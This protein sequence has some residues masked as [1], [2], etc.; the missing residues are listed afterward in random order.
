LKHWLAALRGG[1]L[2]RVS[3]NALEGLADFV[4]EA[5][6]DLAGLGDFVE[7]DDTDAAFVSEEREREGAFWAVSEDPDL[8]DDLFVGHGCF[9]RFVAVNLLWPYKVSTNF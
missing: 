8:T 9:G 3:L 2:P 1:D 5:R 7:G 4:G 6:G